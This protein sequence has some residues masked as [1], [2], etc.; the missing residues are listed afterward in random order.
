L[1]ALKNILVCFEK[2]SGLKCNFEKTV[3]VRIGNLDDDPDPRILELGFTIAT[4][5]K[6]LGFKISQGQER[7]GSNL[8]EL[9]KKVKNTLNFW[10]IFNLSLSGKVT[11]VKS[12]VYPIVNYYLSVLQPT[13]E[14]LDTYSKLL[15]D[16][17]I[18]SL[19][20]SR[21]K[22]YADPVEGGLGLFRPE[23]FFKALSC[24]WMKRCITL[25]HDNW[26]RQLLNIGLDGGIE[27]IQK[28]DASNLGPILK[29]IVNNFV[30]LRNDF[31]II[32]N[33]FIFSPI[34]NN[35]HFTFKNQ[36]NLKVFDNAFF[37]VF[38]IG[39]AEG[40]KKT[41]CWSD[42]AV[43]GTGTL[44]SINQ[45]NNFLGIGLDPAPY[46][47]LAAAFRSAKSKF[48]DRSLASMTFR[49]FISSK[50]KG[51]KRYRDIYMRAHMVKQAKKKPS[52][53]TR[54][55]QIAG[56]E[57]GPKDCIKHL[58][59]L[60]TTHFFPSD[61]KTFL[62]KAHHNI[63]GLN[64]RVHHI[65]PE[66]PPTCTF[67]TKALNLPAERES[68]IHFFWYCPTSSKIIQRFFETFVE[69]EINLV[70]YLTGCIYAGDKVFFSR[71]VLIV[72]NILRFILWNFK[73]RKKLPTWPSVCSEFYY[74]F[75]TLI[76]CS[77]KFQDEV[78]ACN[79]FKQN[80]Q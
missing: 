34:L 37:E 19:N 79:S 47:F 72:F 38:C 20:F 52:P 13:K 9:I 69:G 17:V 54:F 33:N 3:I 68:F 77:R 53:I 36:G 25:G 48:E 35:P 1:A 56:I 80:R 57:N 75:N 10:K 62:F 16:F 5:C 74:F 78:F 23:L 71:P 45:L 18:Q 42:I 26:R 76:K 67:C 64:N 4:E 30:D 21:E 43:P 32:Y 29:Y 22:C 58:N 40:R 12:I 55:F 27:L 66:R 65:N 8:A 46:G 44:K 59:A 50:I 28:S 7:F 70:S 15:E 61:F 41:L 73:L 49:D 60:W 2:L 14:W 11:I 6:L 39:L 24:S 63:L 51:S 31:G